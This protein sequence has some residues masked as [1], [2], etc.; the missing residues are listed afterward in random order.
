[1]RARATRSTGRSSCSRGSTRNRENDDHHN[2]VST[3]AELTEYDPAG[4]ELVR[5]AL[6]ESDFRYVDPRRREATGHLTGLDRSTLPPF[7]WPPEVLEAH[8]STGPR[9]SPELLRSLPPEHPQDA[10]PR[11]QAPS[12]TIHFHNQRD[13][14]VLVFWIDYAGKLQKKSE[15]ASRAQWLGETQV[16][17][18]F[19]VT[20]ERRTPLA[21]FGAAYG[22]SRAVIRR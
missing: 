3:R 4:A 22:S 6:G 12:S 19:L 14:A 10:R 7:F 2:H 11:R 5:E 1:M 13:E 18:C 16:G 8:V 15:L 20:D 21:R 17:H 9:T